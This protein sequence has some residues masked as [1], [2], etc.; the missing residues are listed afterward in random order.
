MIL[1]FIS[2]YRNLE[3]QIE[4]VFASHG[5]AD[6]QLLFLNCCLDLE[7]PQICFRDLSSL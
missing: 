1:G 2:K 5:Y 4:L 6:P 7:K 3:F